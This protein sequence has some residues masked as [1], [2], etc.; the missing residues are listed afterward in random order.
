MNDQGRLTGWTSFLILASLGLVIAAAAVSGSTLP[1]PVVLLYA[2]W[3]ADFAV[4]NSVLRKIRDKRREHEIRTEER[5]RMT[6]QQPP[7]RQERP[8]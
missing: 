2:A 1:L 4:L 3:L 7:Y 8:R 5:A 6:G